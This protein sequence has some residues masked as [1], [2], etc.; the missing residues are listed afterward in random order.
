MSKF[1]DNKKFWWFAGEDPYILSQCSKG[2]R[3]KFSLIGILVILI[4]L[5][6]AAGIA[7][8]VEQILNSTTADIIIGVYFALFIFI[9]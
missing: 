9:L 6:S 2:L 1:L 3:R 7:F 4:S 5:V 8:G